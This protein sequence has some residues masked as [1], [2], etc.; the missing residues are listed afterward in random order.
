MTVLVPADAEE[1]KQAV[2]AAVAHEGPVY[3][4]LER[5]ATPDVPGRRTPGNRQ[6]QPPDRRAHEKAL[7]RQILLHP[8][9]TLLLSRGVMVKE[10]LMPRPNSKP[11]AYGAA[12]PISPVKPF[13]ADL[14]LGMARASKLVVALEEHSIIGGL[15]S[16]VCECLSRLT[17]PGFS[18]LE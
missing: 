16:A 17:Q 12:L 7:F 11:K 10:S 6:G 1:A 18:A 14:C 15:G 8:R 13:D 9:L 5:E 4:R 2:R 3:I